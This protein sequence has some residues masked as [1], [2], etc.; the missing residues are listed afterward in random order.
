MMDHPFHSKGKAITLASPIANKR[1]TIL[2][3]LLQVLVVTYTIWRVAIFEWG[4]EQERG[5]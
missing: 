3:R 4:A 5:F 2:Y 1:N